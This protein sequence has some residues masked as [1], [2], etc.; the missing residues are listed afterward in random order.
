MNSEPFFNFATWNCGGKKNLSSLSIIDDCD[1]IAVQETHLAC[2]RDK[3][4]DHFYVYPYFENICS[5]P[6]NLKTVVRNNRGNERVWNHNEFNENLH[7]NSILVKWEKFNVTK[8]VL[9]HSSEDSNI[10]KSQ[11]VLRVEANYRNGETIQQDNSISIISFYGVTGN[12]KYKKEKALNVLIDA[13]ND[14]EGNLVLVMGDFNFGL[15]RKKA[16]DKKLSAIFKERLNHLKEIF[17]ENTKTVGRHFTFYLYKDKTK[18]KGRSRIDRI[19]W[20]KNERRLYKYVSWKNPEFLQSESKGCQHLC[21]KG[22]FGNT[23]DTETTDMDYQI[24]IN[25]Q[26][27]NALQCDNHCQSKYYI[28]I[29]I[30]SHLIFFSF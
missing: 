12:D 10:L 28:Y 16:S 4:P 26:I 14:A 25:D 9:Y 23:P 27:N 3:I 30:Y 20:M 18:T 17:C 11:R 7:G 24:E 2:I 1:I 19:Y 29:F 22:T 13:V 8:S 5:H 15:D 6:E 21:L